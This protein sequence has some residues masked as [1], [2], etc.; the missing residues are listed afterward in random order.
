MPSYL[1]LWNPVQLED[2][3]TREFRDFSKR[4]FAKT[5]WSTGTRRSIPVGSRVF[6]KRTTQ[7]PRGI[8]A[9]GVSVNSV[10]DDVHWADESKQANYLPMRIDAMVEPSSIDVLPQAALLSNPILGAFNWDRRGSGEEIPEAIADELEG[11][12]KAH[13]A[14]GTPRRTTGDDFAAEVAR[15]LQ[16]RIIERPRGNP[17]PDFISVNVRQPKRSPRVAAWVLQQAKGR[18]ELCKSKA[19]FRRQDYTPYLEVHHLQ[20]LADGGADTP[21]NAVALCPNCHRRLHLGTD[22]KVQTR[23]LRDKLPRLV[24]AKPA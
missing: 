22:A 12:W 8:V 23:W 6:I 13:L 10:F 19:P 1:L 9:S 15:L 2:G 4:G 11:V 16:S 20:R 14:E 18:C 3:L 24:R 5:T 7:E 17:S 21:E